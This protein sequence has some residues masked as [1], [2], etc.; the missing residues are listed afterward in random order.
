MAQVGHTDSAA[1]LCDDTFTGGWVND[2]DGAYC[3]YD[4]DETTYKTDYGALYNW[5]AV[6]NAHGLAPAGWRVPSDTD[7]ATLITFLGGGATGGGIL[8]EIG[9]AHWTT[10]NTGASD[11]YGFMARGAG[12]RGNVIG[13]FSSLGLST[14]YF[15][16][17]QFDATTAWYSLLLY[18]AITIQQLHLTGQKKY[19]LS[20]RCMRDVV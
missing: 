9:V 14:G 4:N 1:K 20:V 18:N 17:N 15:C 16:S 5:Y 10:P 11:D 7:F 8:K 12:Y 3:Y 13:E 6:D 19:G 2:T